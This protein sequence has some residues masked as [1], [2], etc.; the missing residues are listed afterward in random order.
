MKSNQLLNQE[1]LT[2]FTKSI[3]S[4]LGDTPLSN[5]FKLSKGLG[6]PVSAFIE[7]LIANEYSK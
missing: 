6:I 1:D 3:N 5:F 4:K 2:I 7:K